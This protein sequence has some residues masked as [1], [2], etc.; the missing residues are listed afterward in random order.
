MRPAGQFP[1][2]TLLQRFPYFW[3]TLPLA[4]LL[5]VMQAFQLFRASDDS[6]WDVWT[7][8]LSRYASTPV[9]VVAIDEKTLAAYGRISNW[10]RHMYVQALNHLQQ[11]GAS[12]IGLDVLF[13]ERSGQDQ[14]FVQAMQQQGVVLADAEIFGERVPRH[15]DLK[16]AQYG[17][18]LLNTSS[19]NIARTFQT[20]YTFASDQSSQP[21][22]AA[23]LAR[24]AGY[25]VELSETPQ[26]LSY[27]APPGQAFLQIS[28]SDVVQGQF[29]YADVQNRIVLIGVTAGG[30]ERDQFLS[31][32]TRGFLGNP[33]PIAGV[34]A[35]A[36]AVHTL[37][38]GG[39]TAPHPLILGVVSALILLLLVG[40]QVRGLL[41]MVLLAVLVFAQGMLHQEGLMFPLTSLV[42]AVVGGL[43]LRLV[44]AFTDVQKGINA[45]LKRLS[46]QFQSEK[47]FSGSPLKRLELLQEIEE[48]LSQERVRLQ[49]LLDNVDSPMFLSGADG[50]ITLQNPSALRLLGEQPSLQALRQHFDLPDLAEGIERVLQG[51]SSYEALS[52]NGLLT[53]RPVVSG[54]LVGN[55]TP[56]NHFTHLL[57][58]HDQHAAA[59]VHDFRSPLTS[60]MGFAQFMEADASEEQKEI[61]GIMLSEA[62]RIADLI[63]DF[64]MVSRSKAAILDIREVELA[65]LIR[66]AAAVAAPLFTEKHMVLQLDL[67]RTVF[68][69]V[70]DRAI[71]R[72]LLNLLSNAVKYSSPSSEVNVKLVVHNE[73]VLL[74]VQDHGVGLSPEDQQRLFGRFFRSS[75]PAIQEVKGTGLG[76][77]TVKE[78]IK[79][80][81]G[82]IWVDS[83]LGKGSTF[84]IH[85]PLKETVL[86]PELV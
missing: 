59:I 14:E 27:N 13:P 83:R 47:P 20:Q 70:D 29:R 62:R 11:A 80:H 64:L 37:I 82:E 3:R 86:L 24:K 9:V 54:G 79:A 26:Y 66:R 1:L 78:L 38:Q 19:G 41:V 84:T 10:D 72:A 50:K 46:L 71:T 32:Y 33:L 30:V 58:Q 15:P 35:Q 51:Q 39:F 65:S 7:R 49:V 31:P 44:F 76:L 67:P 45:Q 74:S 85:L 55:V 75:N 53:L 18:I 36:T 17:A 68:V 16:N 73:E 2:L 77:H 21:S 4:L 23:Q 22:F 40:S 63:D 5:L 43:L 61:L 28:F 57:E 52:E 69:E 25:G 42:L 56:T 6:F 60:I 48:K 81:G 12:A 34:E 8:L